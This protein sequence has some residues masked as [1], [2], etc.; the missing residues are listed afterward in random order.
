MRRRRFLKTSTG[1]G[2]VL[3][4]G[5]AGD[6][7]GTGEFRL[8]ISDQPMA[9]EEFDS[10]DV[11]L[12]SARIFQAGDDEELTSAVV[13]DTVNETEEGEDGD[14]EGFVEFD[15]DNVTV[16]LTTV[17]GD[18][19][20]SVVE[21]ELEAGRYSGIELRVANAEGVVDGES[22]DV[23][24]PSDRLRIVRPFEIGAD[25]ELDFVFDITVI[26]KGPT[27]GY[28]LLPVIG[29]SGVAG[30]DVEVEEVEPEETG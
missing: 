1:V 18:R 29:K 11:T 23:M 8:L 16:D 13:N 20:V 5:C 25:E 2:I 4:A 6:D 30:D 10:L 3:L 22:V 19:A 26:Q 9:I 24:V 7:T 15:I 28:N 21:G 14:G 17:K 12:S 27:G